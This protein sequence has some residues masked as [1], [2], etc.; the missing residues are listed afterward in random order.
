M[1]TDVQ[2]TTAHLLGFNK[3]T[4][5]RVSQLIRVGRH[6]RRHDNIPV[7]IQSGTIAIQ[8]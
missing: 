3:N 2:Y 7:S 5:Q 6:T 8:K 1:Y 4:L